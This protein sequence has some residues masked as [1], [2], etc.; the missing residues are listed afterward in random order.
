MTPRGVGSGDALV[1]IVNK[2]LR[3]AQTPDLD[4][5]VAGSTGA[6]ASARTRRGGRFGGG[7]YKEP[8]AGGAFCAALARE[9]M[10]RERQKARE[11]QDEGRRKGGRA[12]Q[13]SSVEPFHQA[14]R[15]KARDLVGKAVGWSAGFT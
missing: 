11:R 7:L 4:S 12:R 5:G 14:E 9:L 1:A 13:G 3:S 8:T 6:R 15:Q 10:A 2:D